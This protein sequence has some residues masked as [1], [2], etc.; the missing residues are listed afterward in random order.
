MGRAR[1]VGVLT[2]SSEQLEVGVAVLG[3]LVQ[4]F[5][6]STPCIFPL[7]GFLLE[8]FPPPG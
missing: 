6:F 4:P 2:Y 1:A 5:L 8:L 7:H 3:S